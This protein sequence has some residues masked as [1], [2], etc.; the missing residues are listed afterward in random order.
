MTCLDE[1]MRIGGE[2]EFSVGCLG[3]KAGTL[4]GPSA[5]HVLWTDTGRSA[6]YI[7]ACA[8]RTASN[9]GMAWLPAYCC[10]S[11]S[12][13]FRQAGFRINYYPADDLIDSFGD[14]PQPSAG[15]V[16][17][18]VHYFGHRNTRMLDGFD[19]YRA[20]GV[21][22]VEDFVQAGLNSSMSLTADF[23]VTSYRKLLP[24]PDGSTVMSRKA[25]D[26]EAIGLELAAPDEAFVSGKLA[27]KA[28]RA[29]GA[30]AVDFLPL[31]EGAEASLDRQV[32][33]RKVSHISQ[34]M[35]ARMDMQGIAL[36]RRKNWLQLQG[37]LTPLVRAERLRP[38]MTD[39]HEGEVP[40]GFPIIVAPASR[41]PLKRYL[42]AREIYCPVHWVLDFLPE[43]DVFARER[44]VAATV[45][46]LPIDQRMTN[47]H[48]EYMADSIADFFRETT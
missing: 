15:D 45:L 22:L 40:L 16:L 33:P 10:E 28:L 14:L 13:A 17:L 9:S 29:Q 47:R 38:L 20:A 5:P 6:L 42:A 30:A 37:L 39:L 23:G 43:P 25:I 34:W 44:A 21:T 24:V 35:L 4:M 48:V 36:S 11:V 27:G 46:T 18:I 26:L 1:S 8:I 41:D 32:I 3:G 7:I 31:L 19:R 12:Q 2:F